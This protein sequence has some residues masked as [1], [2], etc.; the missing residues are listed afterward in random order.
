MPC[1]LVLASS[2]Y[3][4]SRRLPT[5]TLVWLRRED[6]FLAAQISND[7]GKAGAANIDGVGHGKPLDSVG[8]YSV[9]RKGSAK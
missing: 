6:M 7:Q 1:R 8:E 3:R 4:A 5:A 9:A 2:G